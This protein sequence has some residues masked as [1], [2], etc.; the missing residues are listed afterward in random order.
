MN[1]WIIVGAVLLMMMSKRANAKTLLKEFEGLSLTR[2]RD[3]SGFDHIGYGH[4][5]LAGEDW[6]KIS[7][8]GAEQL[9]AKDMQ[10]AE[11]CVSMLVKVPLN[12]NQRA[13]L[14]SFV[15]NIGCGAFKN[16]TMLG[17]L[18][19]REYAQA[20][21]EF[22]KWN[23]VGGKVVMGLVTRRRKEREIFLS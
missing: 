14:I 9:L 6:Q 11:N 23:K 21:D 20:A 19:D 7:I 10:H 5:L 18:N 17:L 22:S 12:S 8:M 4:K 15:Y 2:Y 13:A 1:V 3:D 16:S